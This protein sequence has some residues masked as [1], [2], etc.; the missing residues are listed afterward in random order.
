MAGQWLDTFVPDH[1]KPG[2]FTITS[3]PSVA[4]READPYLEL[5]VQHA[6]EN[7]A[8]AW[9]WRP[10]KE[11]VGKALSVRIGGSFVLP[12]SEGCG[13]AKRIILVAGGVGINPLVSMLGYLA[14]QTLTDMEV[15]VLYTSKLPGDKSLDSILFLRGLQAT[16]VAEKYLEALRCLSLGMTRKL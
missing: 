2:G 11:I 15:S 6:P 7:P 3:T 12:P 1:S 14:E 16:S 4:A 13:R 8:A 5:A 9:L 10:E